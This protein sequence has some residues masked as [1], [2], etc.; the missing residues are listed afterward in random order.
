M[1][2]LTS[3]GLRPPI[4]CVGLGSGETSDPDRTQVQNVTNMEFMGTPGTFG[5]SW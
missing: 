5:N 1:S 4:P 2:I 3:G